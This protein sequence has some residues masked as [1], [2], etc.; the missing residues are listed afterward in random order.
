MAEPARLHTLVFDLDDTL[1][2]ER[3]FVFSGFSA[4]D[5]WLVR[6][7]GVAGFRERAVARFEA[8]SRGRIFDEALAALGLSEP[9][10][11]AQ[12]VSVYRNHLP[13][14]ALPEESAALLADAGRRYRLALVSDGYLEVQKRKAAALGVA[15]W[16]PVQVFSD[17]WGREAWK[18]SERPF[19]EVMRQLPGS[20]EGYVYVAD[21]PR[22]DFIAP[23]ALGWRTVR[24]RRAGGEHA[25]YVGSAAEAAEAEVG[26]MTEL[27]AWLGL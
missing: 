2:P 26:S 1:Y 16:I 20:P 11:V 23:R 3:D 5:E 6:E 9:A 7:R 22:K 24:F 18:P 8:G 21:N 12:M 27:R 4:V 17:A 19:Q 14:I 25:D 13:A 10:T 15:R